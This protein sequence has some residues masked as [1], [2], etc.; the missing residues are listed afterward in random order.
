MELACTRKAG[1]LQSEDEID[2]KGRQSPS[3]YSRL[4]YV[5]IPSYFTLSIQH[6]PYSLADCIYQY[7]E[8]SLLFIVMRCWVQGYR[9]IGLSCWALF[10][11]IV[12]SSSCLICD[13]W[14]ELTNLVQQKDRTCRFHTGHSF[15]RPFK[16][17]SNNIQRPILFVWDLTWSPSGKICWW[18][19]F[20]FVLGPTFECYRP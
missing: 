10:G 11:C 2:A 5:H 3:V 12:A 8:I 14:K 20:S 16:S 6:V 7:I 4:K 1:K 9:H 18:T 13:A 19:V 17:C 15:P